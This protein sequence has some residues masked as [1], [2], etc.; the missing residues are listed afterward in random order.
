MRAR[1]NTCRSPATA[2]LE[3][4]GRKSKHEKP[5]K[6]RR[7]ESQPK[8]KTESE[9][10]VSLLGAAKDCTYIYWYCYVSWKFSPQVA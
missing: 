6:L 5:G 9:A 7:L 1:E 4:S 3:E 8:F 2:T 10:N